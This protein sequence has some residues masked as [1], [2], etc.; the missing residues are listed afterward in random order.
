[1]EDDLIFYKWKRLPNLFV[2]ERQPRFLFFNGRRPPPCKTEDNLIV[3]END[4]IVS[5][6]GRRHQICYLM[7]DN[8]EY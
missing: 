1:M 6:N 3:M 5:A 4:Q 7:E 8:S 2:N